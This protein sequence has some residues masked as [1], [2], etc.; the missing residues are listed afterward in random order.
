MAWRPH[1]RVRV[2]ARSPRAGACCDRCGLLYNQE[3]LRFQYEWAGLRLQN[4]KLLVCR[5]CLD[6]P[7]PQLRAKILAPDPVPIYNARPE[8]FTTTGFSYQ[9]TNIMTMPNPLTFGTNVDGAQM[10]MPDGVTVV[11]MPNAA[12]DN[13]LLPHYTGSDFNDDFSS[14]FG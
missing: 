2:N 4:L 13:P 3:N 14:D 11:T 5:E 12:E 9:E 7:Q 6:V 8:P 10:L 1:G